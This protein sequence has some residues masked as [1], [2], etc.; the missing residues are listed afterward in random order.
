MSPPWFGSPDKERL[1]LQ[2]MN[3]FTYVNS[4][5]SSDYDPRCR[6]IWAYEVPQ[7]AINCDYLMC[8]VLSCAALHIHIH[9]PGDHKMRRAAHDYFGNAILVLRRQLPQINSSNADLVFAA[10]ILI[11]FQS[12]TLWLD[13]CNKCDPSY[14]LPTQ[15]LQM[16]QGVGKVLRAAAKSGALLSMR[17]LLEILPRK[18]APG[19]VQDGLFRALGATMDSAVDEDVETE[20]AIRC[21]LGHVMSIFRGI[22]T[23][24]GGP[25]TR[26][27]LLM[28]P[29][30]L[31]PR[32][33]ELLEAH[34]PRAVVLLAYF[35]AATKVVD[36]HWWLKGRAEY[37]VTGML[38]LL[39]EA[40]KEHLA[41]PLAV[42]FEGEAAVRRS[43][44]GPSLAVTE[45]EDSAAESV[46]CSLS[47]SPTFSPS[48]SV[49][50]RCSITSR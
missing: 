11:A 49:C 35:F 48:V 33:I 29:V 12:S 25:M 8:A 22:W 42:V 10:S 31:R 2:L 37:E 5:G 46:V 38:S 34:D 4:T 6:R 17:P 36:Q 7:M 18:T 39:P 45:S 24:E 30:L 23:G 27:R 13:P 14:H 16:E 19:E 9:Q 1:D 32:F 40:W 43:E 47:R 26:R 41:W 28:F 44:L 20:A 3:L 21:A 15:W 50:T